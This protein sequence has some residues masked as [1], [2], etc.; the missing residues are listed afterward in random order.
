MSLT[1]A[2]RSLRASAVSSSGAKSPRPSAGRTRSSVP[3]R[4]AAYPSILGSMISWLVPLWASVSGRPRPRAP[5]R[6]GCSRPPRA[7]RSWSRGQRRSR[8]CARTPRRWR[9]GARW[10]SRL[11]RR[12]DPLVLGLAASAG[13]G[14]DLVRVPGRR[15][16]ISR[17]WSRGGQ[18]RPGPLSSVAAAAARAWSA[19]S[20][21]LRILAWRDSIALLSGGRMYFVTRHKITATTTSSTKNVPLGGGTLIGDHVEVTFFP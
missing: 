6:R 12:D 1:T 7:Q 18:R 15:P 5:G 17:A 13:L 4:A 9:A 2:R 10:R 19:A 3:S 14:L 16:T 21:A 11:G 20:R 8:R